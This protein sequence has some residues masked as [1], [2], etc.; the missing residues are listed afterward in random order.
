MP[1]RISQFG[2]EST[3]GTFWRQYGNS[4]CYWQMFES[5][6]CQSINQCWSYSLKKVDAFHPKVVSVEVCQ[7][8]ARTKTHIRLRSNRESRKAALECS[9]EFYAARN[10][11]V[12]FLLDQS[13]K[14]LREKMTFEFAKRRFNF[15]ASNPSL[16][17][18]SGFNTINQLE[19]Y[20]H[21]RPIIW[22]T[23]HLWSMS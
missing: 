22:P 13:F 4:W 17:I 2:S 14:I 5:Q 6:P 21:I 23:W 11:S 15:F 3:W 10:F 1:Y 20:L 7:T 18:C 12:S 16:N 19:F 8:S 9:L